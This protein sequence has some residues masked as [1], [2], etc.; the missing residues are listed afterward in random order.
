MLVTCTAN[1]STKQQNSMEQSPSETGSSSAFMESE[2]SLPRSQEPFAGPYPEPHEFSPHLPSSKI[3]SNIILSSRPRRVVSFFTSE[4]PTKIL[5]AFLVSRVC[6]MNRPLHL[7][8]LNHPNNIWCS[9]Q[10][11]KPLIMLCSPAFL[12][13]LLGPDVLSYEALVFFEQTD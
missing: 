5:Y 12:H 1:S 10:V 11:M 13:F 6:Y 7:P 2:G 4:F 9:V 8:S 3:Q